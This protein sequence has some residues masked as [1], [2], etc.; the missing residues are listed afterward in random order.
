MGVGSTNAFASGTLISQAPRNCPRVPANPQ[1]MNN[2]VCATPTNW[3]ITSEQNGNDGTMTFNYS[4]QSSTGRL[5]DL[6]PCTLGETVFYPGNNSPYVWPSPMVASSINPTVIPPNPPQ[7]GNGVGGTSVDH[8][9]PPNSYQTPYAYAHFQATQRFW[10]ICPCY[11]GGNITNIVPDLTI[12]RKVFQDTDQLW[13]YQIT[14][15]GYTNTV[16][17]P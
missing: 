6:A 15:S 13:K 7:P 10:F 4:F 9:Y 8:N 14:K 11:N 17:L 5:Q 12:D 2:V 1:N 16:R 3:T